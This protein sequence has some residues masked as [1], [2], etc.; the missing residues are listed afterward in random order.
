MTPTQLT[1]SLVVGAVLLAV[2]GCSTGSGVTGSASCEQPATLASAAEVAAGEAVVVSA[3]GMVDGCDDTGQDEALDPLVD[4]AVIW[5][6]GGEQIELAR[7]DADP[8]GRIEVEVQ[9]PADAATDAPATLTI[10][11]AAP[12]DVH[13]MP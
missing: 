6:Q 11:F 1:R 13:V 12:A 2:A 3:D 8:T 4:Q 9:V 5:E 10:G 7:A